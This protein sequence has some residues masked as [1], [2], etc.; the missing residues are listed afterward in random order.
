MSVMCTHMYALV[1]VCEGRYC[2]N[3]KQS[4]MTCVFVCVCVCER[5]REREHHSIPQCAQCL[6]IVDVSRAQSCY[7]GSP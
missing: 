3:V 7:H 1:E 2:V 6:L 4:M 5:E